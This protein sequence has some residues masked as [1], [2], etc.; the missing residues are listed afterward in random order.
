[1]FVATMKSEQIYYQV[2]S[3]ASFDSVYRRIIGFLPRIE[4]RGNSSMAGLGRVRGYEDRPRT[5]CF[6]QSDKGQ[7]AF[8]KDLC[9]QVESA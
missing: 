4:R 1:M 7:K 5:A 3:W 2:P 6:A 8:V 9:M